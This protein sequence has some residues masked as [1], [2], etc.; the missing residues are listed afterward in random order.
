MIKNYL[1]FVE[2]SSEKI[3]ETYGKGILN[4]FFK[5]LTALGFKDNT[6]QT[7]EVPS[8]FLIFFKFTGVDASKIEAVFKRF[9]SLS[10]I[11]VD[12]T[13]PLMSLYFGIKNNGEFEY[14]YYHDEL[15]PIGVFKLNK[16]T[17]NSIKLS[18]LKSSS[19]LKKVLLNLSLNDILLFG[20]IK[21]EMD[22]FTPGYFSQKSSPILNDRLITFGYYGYGKWSE[23]NLDVESENELKSNLKTFLSKYKWSEKVQIRVYSSNFWSMIDIK[24]K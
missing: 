20:K 15:V 16:S 2:S 10:S 7:K 18:E 22:K 13:H 9:K 3:D 6:P 12:Y 24:I 5:C 17:L 4:T 21:V 14:G 23:G 8:E 19:G 1:N 11:P